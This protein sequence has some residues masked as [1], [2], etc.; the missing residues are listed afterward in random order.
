MALKRAVFCWS[1]KR[2]T[3]ETVQGPALSLKSVDDVH[4][5]DGLP[6]GVLCVGDGVTDDVLEEH[7]QD[8]TGFF[9]N[10]TRD[11]LDTTSASQTADG[12]FRDTL[13]VVTKNLSVTLGAPLSKTFSS[14]TSARHVSELTMRTLNDSNGKSH[15]YLSYVSARLMP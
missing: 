2:L 5:G 13:D 15:Y 4:G 1:E 12:G 7:L 14:F 8:T 9:V 10:E 3:S 11:S 6:L